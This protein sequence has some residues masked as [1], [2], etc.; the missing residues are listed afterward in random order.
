MNVPAIP[1]LAGDVVE[2]DGCVIFGRNEPTAKG[3]AGLDDL[4][5]LETTKGAFTLRPERPDDA[6]FLY[7]L[8][9]SHMQPGVA[10]MP[11]DDAMKES[12]LRMQFRSQTMTY[13]AEY[14]E[15]R[16]SILERDGVPF[17]RLVLDEADGVATFVDFALLPENRSGGLGT[18][19]M[20]RLM[21]WVAE[22]CAVA[23][24]NILWHNEASLRM[25]RRIGFVQ[26]GETP[27][28]VEMEWRRG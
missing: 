8:F 16:F 21:D 14:P 22:R 9:R 27:P 25:T 13:R 6:D 20:L 4:L 17:G 26:V 7:A 10:A 1:G 5:V 24:L 23:R 12:L 3:D 18:A 28:Y 19:V 15:A 11:V 2:P